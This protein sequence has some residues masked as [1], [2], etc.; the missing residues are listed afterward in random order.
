MSE[1]ISLDSSETK[2]QKQR[3]YDGNGKFQTNGAVH[4]ACD[5]RLDCAHRLRGVR[6]PLGH[7]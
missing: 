7:H 4:R 2:N 5:M 1:K 3:K 6:H